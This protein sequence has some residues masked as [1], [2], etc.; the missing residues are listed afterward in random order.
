M[1]LPRLAFLAP[2]VAC[3]LSTAAFVTSPALADDTAACLDAS[4]KGQTMRDAHQLIEAR[5]Q[6]RACAQTSCPAVVRR[7]CTAWANELEQSVPTVVLALK[8]GAGHDVFDAHVTV[9]GKPFVDSLTG[10]ATAIDPGA[11]TFRFVRTDGTMVDQQVLVG[12][13]QRDVAV[14][15]HLAPALESAPLVPGPTLL[16]SPS[17]GTSSTARTVG[18]IVGGVGVAGLIVGGVFG[19]L[20]AADKGNGGC[21]AND[22]CTNWG[23]ISNAKTAADVADVGLIAGGVLAATGGALV[24]FAHGPRKETALRLT[25]SVSASAGGLVLRGAW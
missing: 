23:A 22:K 13:G 14:V 25:P 8:D 15:A 3:A 16:P 11:H 1:N 17:E 12:E 21:G 24:L 10:A 9:D 2:L 18:W 5:D 6:F 19:G 20:A 4:S 7:D